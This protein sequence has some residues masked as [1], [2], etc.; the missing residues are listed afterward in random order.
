MECDA[1]AGAGGGHL[2]IMGESPLELGGCRLFFLDGGSMQVRVPLA[3]GLSLKLALRPVLVRAPWGTALLDCG[4]GEYDAS[5]W[6]RY[7]VR[8]PLLPFPRQLE[9]I[10]VRPEEVDLVFLSHL[11]FDH[12]GGLLRGGRLAF[13]RA[14]H[15]LQEKEWHRARQRGGYGPL[16]GTLAGGRLRL[17]QG[18]T[19]IVPGLEA[20]PAPGHTEGH[21]VCRVGGSREEAWFLA[22]LVPAARSLA[23]GPDRFSDRD[24]DLALEH[25]RRTV[26]G[27]VARG[28]LALFYHDP[29]QAWARLDWRIEGQAA[30]AFAASRE[31]AGIRRDGAAAGL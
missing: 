9:R 8:A 2:S 4:P 12:A 28:A 26:T 30:R 23:L 6:R 16:T 1:G 24:P 7:G 22:D 27:M 5:S 29:R 31:G 20:L 3:R 18:A 14:D 13:P 10:G 11:H 19:E 25:R 15:L 21:Q 17:L